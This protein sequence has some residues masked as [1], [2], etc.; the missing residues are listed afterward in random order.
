MPFRAST[1]L[2]RPPVASAHP[3]SPRPTSPAPAPAPAP[4]SSSA[5]SSSGID[6]SLVHSALVSDEFVRRTG[7]SGAAKRPVGAQDRGDKRRQFAAALGPENEPAP[8]DGADGRRALS[9]SRKSV[10]GGGDSPSPAPSAAASS[11]S[12]PSTLHH[13]RVPRSSPKLAAAALPA[14]PSSAAP[15]TCSTPRPRPSRI[16]SERGTPRTRPAA[17]PALSTL[18]SVSSP[19]PAP[20]RSPSPCPLPRARPPACAPAGA[21]PP[22]PPCVPPLE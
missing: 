6:P 21:A 5:G 1:P 14:S 12:S 15:V 11:P 22:L 13:L 3:S 18:R 10:G 2:L 20:S 19:V 8:S 17:A 16:R 4:L 7:T 9:R